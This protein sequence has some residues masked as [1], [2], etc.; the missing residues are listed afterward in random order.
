MFKQ[1][2]QD[3]ISAI[4][5]PGSRLPID[6]LAK[7]F[8]SSHTPIRE[9]LQRLVERGLVVTK[10]HHGYWV[11]TLTPEEIQDIFEMRV[12]LECF[13]LEKMADNIPLM[14]IE[15]LLEKSLQLKRGVISATKVRQV[16]DRLDDHIH[17]G[18]LVARCNNSFVYMC[19][20][21]VYDYISLVRHLNKRI[22]E[23]NNEHI[24]FLKALLDGNLEVAKQKLVDHLEA[25]KEACVAQ[26]NEKGGENRKANYLKGRVRV[27]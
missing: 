22:M 16:F 2:H 20:N 14:Q 15:K 12:V 1:L 11:R 10:G 4:F 21:Y 18:L 27:A 5:P 13:C 25:A 8:G 9:A 17:V 6:A 24:E 23:A 26:Y 7:R 19:Y 3:I